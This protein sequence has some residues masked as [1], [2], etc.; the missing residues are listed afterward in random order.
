LKLELP[1]ARPAVKLIPGD[2]ASQAKELLRLLH[3]EAKVI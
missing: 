2:P 1:A 3:E